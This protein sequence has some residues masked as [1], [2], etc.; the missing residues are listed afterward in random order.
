MPPVSNELR[1]RF[2][3]VLDRFD[4]AAQAWSALC[5]RTPNIERQCDVEH[6][7]AVPERYLDMRYHLAALADSDARAPIEPLRRAAQ[8]PEPQC[9]HCKLPLK[10]PAHRGAKAAQ[11]RFWDPGSHIDVIAVACQSCGRLWSVD[12]S[13][14]PAPPA[15]MRP[16]SKSSGW[17][18]GDRML[19]AAVAGM[20]AGAS[21]AAWLL[22]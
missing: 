9:A 3:G 11:G 8:A 13:Q 7:S 21:I 4:E 15:S 12:A 17:S 5:A 22:H 20:G 6:L 18:V 16:A 10:L 19:A 14:L 2:Q 1:A